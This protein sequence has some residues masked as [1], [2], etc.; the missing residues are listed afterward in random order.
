MSG[1]RQE[2][3]LPE[4][5]FRILGPMRVK[6]HGDSVD[7]GPRKQQIVLAALLCN[8]NSLVSVDAL[9]EALWLGSPPR[10]AR[11]NVQVYVSALRGLIRA[12]PVPGIS[13]QNGGYVLHVGPADLDSL[14]FEQLVRDASKLRQ[15]GPVSAVA[16]ALAAALRLWRGRALDG[17]R[18]VPLLRA[19]AERL[20][21][22][23]LAA[24]EDWTE[25]EIELGGG[26]EVVERITEVAQRH[27]LRERLRILQMI[28]LC[29]AERRTE[30][31]A[32]Y[33]ELLTGQLIDGVARGRHRLV[34]V[35]GPL[36]AG[37]TALAVHAAHQLGDGFPDGR[38]FVRLLSAAGK[39]RPV[40]QVVA[41][42]AAAGQAP[43]AGPA[44]RAWR[45]WLA[46][47]HALVI[48]D[49]ARR[50]SEV[51]PLL[52]ETGDSAVI[53]TAR[54]RLA[55]LEAAWRLTAPPF[56]VPEAL[57]F[58]GR[59]AGARNAARGERH[60]R[61]E[62]GEVRARGPPWSGGSGCGPSCLTPSPPT[63][64]TPGSTA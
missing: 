42:L 29:Q 38:F 32:V 37:K 60:H 43:K 64:G 63:R 41:E 8:A 54:C 31:L 4:L 57:E 13:H 47:H 40:E 58:L 20:D 61:A 45:E 28:A 25:A 2:G 6:V 34:V 50:E 49:G 9:A 27:P 12:D 7:A 14:R 48:L 55:G 3:C 39:A 1:S 62:R 18:D 44:S 33:D 21:R 22:Q 5:R 56:S 35:T 26:A 24:F 23:Y 53:V 30:A 46:G 16:D 52:P 59:G 10:T 36:G 19:A 15:A 11:K 17:M 51:R